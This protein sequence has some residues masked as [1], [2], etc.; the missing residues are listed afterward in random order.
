MRLRC[1]S[2]RVHEEITRTLQ[3]GHFHFQDYAAFFVIN[4]TTDRKDLLVALGIDP[5]R[6]IQRGGVS[7]VLT[8]T[9]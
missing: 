4:G 1:S 3:D 9:L 6:T 7:N 2:R 8:V 5:T